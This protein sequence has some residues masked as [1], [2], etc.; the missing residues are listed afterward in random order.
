[1]LNG[2]A[3]KE[4]SKLF[5]LKHTPSDFWA[6]PVPN[7]FPQDAKSALSRRNG[8]YRE[9]VDLQHAVLGGGGA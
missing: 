8:L 5:D 7:S 9:E 1:M 3:L 4:Q 2:V 6:E